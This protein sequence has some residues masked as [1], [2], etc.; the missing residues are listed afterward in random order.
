MDGSTKKNNSSFLRRTVDQS[1]PSVVTSVGCRD[2]DGVSIRAAN[3]G[4]QTRE[5]PN[6]ESGRA[7]LDVVLRRP[8]SLRTDVVNVKGGNPRRSP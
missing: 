6:L 5:R 8:P 4:V 3:A 7:V 2:G 1:L